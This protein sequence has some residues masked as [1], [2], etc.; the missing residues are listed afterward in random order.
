MALYYKLKIVKKSWNIVYILATFFISTIFYEFLHDFR[1]KF[2]R[3]LAV[4]FCKT[5]KWTN[6]L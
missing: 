4:I 6:F 5:L 1:I 3:H 2:L